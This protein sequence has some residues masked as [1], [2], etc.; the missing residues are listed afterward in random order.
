MQAQKEAEDEMWYHAI[1]ARLYDQRPGP[2]SLQTVAV[3]EFLVVIMI[4]LSDKQ[5]A[6]IQ[7]AI[8]QIYNSNNYGFKVMQSQ[9]GAFASYGNYSR[10]GLMSKLWLQMEQFIHNWFRKWLLMSALI[11]TNLLTALLLHK[12]AHAART[13]QQ[14]WSNYQHAEHFMLNYLRSVTQQGKYPELLDAKEQVQSMHQNEY[15]RIAKAIKYSDQV[16][17]LE[18]RTY[19][20]VIGKSN[21]LGTIT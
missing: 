3:Q 6:E 4:P 5:L 11:G 2:T 12:V 9:H 7:Q 19:P 14:I 20:P 13:P 18:K 1:L 10:Q 8:I 17:L 16:I 15:E 21:D